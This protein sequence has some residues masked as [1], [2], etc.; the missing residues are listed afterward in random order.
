MNSRDEKLN[1]GAGSSEAL[2]TLDNADLPKIIRYKSIPDLLEDLWRSDTWRREAYYWT[3]IALQT[4]LSSGGYYRY[5]VESERKSRP[6]FRRGEEKR[7]WLGPTVFPGLFACRVSDLIIICHYFEGAERLSRIISKGY[8]LLQDRMRAKRKGVLLFLPFIS[9]VATDRFIFPSQG[10]MD[11]RLEYIFHE[12]AVVDYLIGDYEKVWVSL[13]TLGQ[14]LLFEAPLFKE[15]PR[16]SFC[17]RSYD[18]L[19][20]GCS[21]AETSLMLKFPLDR[22]LCRLDRQGELR[23]VREMLKLKKR[24]SR[25]YFERVSPPVLGS[26]FNFISR[27]MGKNCLDC[28]HEIF[29]ILH[30][31]T[32]TNVKRVIEIAVSLK[33][34]VILEEWEKEIVQ[35]H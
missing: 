11:H 15:F 23:V 31:H 28:L 2:E 8:S 22:Y 33:W 6:K 14:L 9:P 21:V 20:K 5:P 32:G 1:C 30:S 12:Y 3:L 26:F 24:T 29:Q 34:N 17:H 4:A 18:F 7:L 27:R 35:G 13:F 19:L 25:L 16:M 10:P